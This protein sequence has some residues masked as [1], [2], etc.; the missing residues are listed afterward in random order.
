MNVNFIALLLAL[1]IESYLIGNI[2]FSVRYDW[3]DNYNAVM[4]IIL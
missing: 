1:K 2:I 3:T 4:A